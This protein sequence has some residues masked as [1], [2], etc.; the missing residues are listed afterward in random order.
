MLTESIDKTATVAASGGQSLG[1][2]KITKL[3]AAKRQIETSITLWFQEAD[4]VSIHTLTTAARQILVDLNA[5]A[6][7]EPMGADHQMIRPEARIIARKAMAEAE[8][9][10]KHADR[11]PEAS[12]LFSPEAT[13]FYLLEAI[14]KYQELAREQ[15][16]LMKLYL[17]YHALT[18]PRIFTPKFID[19]MRSFFPSESTTCPTKQQFLTVV[20]PAIIRKFVE[21]TPKRKPLFPCLPLSSR[22]GIRRATR[23]E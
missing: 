14:D 20:L 9:F 2:L 4:P 7:G 18:H 12:C 17:V 1:Q 10:F 13:R 3:E 5:K 8:N 11:D 16:P 6:G 23:A 19:L 21:I 22:A 15:P